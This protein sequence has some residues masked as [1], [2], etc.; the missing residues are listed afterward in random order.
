MWIWCGLYGQWSPKFLFVKSRN[1]RE[2]WPNMEI[3]ITE[4]TNCKVFQVQYSMMLSNIHK[5]R[6]ERK[7]FALGPVF[8]FL[9]KIRRPRLPVGFPKSRQTDMKY[10]PIKYSNG[11]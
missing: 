4:R 6:G 5:S 10:I 2:I 8:A 1:A 3:W 11:R 9:E 7:V